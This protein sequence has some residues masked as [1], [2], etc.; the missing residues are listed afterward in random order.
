MNTVM[1]LPVA[2]VVLS[3]KKK[4]YYF[5]DHSE[6]FFNKWNRDTIIAFRWKR[7]LEGSGFCTKFDPLNDFFKRR[8]S[9][10]F[11]A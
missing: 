8:V 10:N 4:K 7:F 2:L 6:F 11:K 5:L 9:Y 3:T 1:A